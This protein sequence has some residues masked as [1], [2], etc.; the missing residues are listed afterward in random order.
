MAKTSST[1]Y[2]E[3]KFWEIITD[4]QK[5]NNLSSR[6][7]AIQLILKE[8]DILR[9]I[10]FNNIKINVS[11]E[12]NIVTKPIEN[13]VKSEEPIETEEDNENKIDPRVTSSLFNIAK[14]MKTEGN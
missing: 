1:I 12:S 5:K 6:N 9:R 7:D 14:T 4:Y 10:D 11:S 3:Q 8:W 13:F 2:L